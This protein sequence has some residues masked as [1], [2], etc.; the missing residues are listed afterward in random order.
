MVASLAVYAFT[1]W[2][3]RR[4]ERR[5]ERR[6]RK[7]IDELETDLASARVLVE[8]HERKGGDDGSSTKHYRQSA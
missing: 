7:L 2:C 6:Y 4:N 5:C 8:A 1:I 3:E